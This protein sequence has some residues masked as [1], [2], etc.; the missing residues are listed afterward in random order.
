MASPP[1]AP[2]ADLLAMPMPVLSD[3]GVVDPYDTAFNAIEN[4]LTVTDRVT[5]PNVDQLHN[6]CGFFAEIFEKWNQVSEKNSIKVHKIMTLMFSLDKGLICVTDEAKRIYRHLLNLYVQARIIKVAL[7]N[8]QTFVTGSRHLHPVPSNL[9]VTYRGVLRFAIKFFADLTN[10][11]R[12]LL[13]N[14]HTYTLTSRE[15]YAEDWEKENYA[16]LVDIFNRFDPSVKPNPPQP[17]T[18]L[19]VT[20]PA[21]TTPKGKGSLKSSA[22]TVRPPSP[23][24]FVFLEDTKEGAK[25]IEAQKKKSEEVKVKQANKINGVLTNLFVHYLP[26]LITLRTEFANE[27]LTQLKESTRSLFFHAPGKPTNLQKNYLLEVL[28]SVFDLL[29]Y[30]NRQGFYNVDEK[31]KT[32][33]L[34]QNA[35]LINEAEKSRAKILI[36]LKTVIIEIAKLRLQ[37]KH[38]DI[39]EVVY[40]GIGSAAIEFLEAYVT[41]SL[42]GFIL[43]RVSQEDDKHNLKM[44]LD[45][46]E[47][48]TP[49]LEAYRVTAND[50]YSYAYGNMVMQILERLIEFGNPSGVVKIAT[51]A[52]K[53]A[54]KVGFTQNSLPI[55]TVEIGEKIQA[56]LYKLADSECTMLPFL[57]IKQLFFDEDKGKMSLPLKEYLSM[58][59][60]DRNKFAQK[61][62]SIFQGFIFKKLQDEMGILNKIVPS[63][64]E[65][66]NTLCIRF[67]Q[68]SQSQPLLL[69]VLLEMLKALKRGIER[70]I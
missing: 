13:K 27:L 65:F 41:P 28:M 22:K 66:C 20:V 12:E 17:L 26:F 48:P 15:V 61:S 35:K 70:K 68:I 63:L 52:L 59:P 57:V 31:D 18:P 62:Y 39:P 32:P 50:L 38:P 36:E 47:G 16:A 1:I 44:D 7:C 43:D 9:L 6:A 21:P 69:K 40:S 46:E 10:G 33:L 25:V 30:F 49:P 34:T 29:T 23:D 5:L 14:T 24:D 11:D 8:I 19:P 64:P 51:E 60:A 3:Y 4:F 45:N 67:W 58:K 37:E 42:V 56:F 2:A 53:L 55:N 54:N